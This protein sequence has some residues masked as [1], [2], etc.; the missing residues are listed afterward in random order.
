MI[1]FLLKY[2]FES[3]LF[4]FMPEKWVK[5]MQL[6]RIQKIFEWSKENSEFYK[7]IY[8]DAGIL[9]LQIR[10][11]E[12]IKK[13]PIV[14]KEMILSHETEF[15]LTRPKSANLVITGTSGSTGKPIDIYLTKREHFTSYI[16]TFLALPAYNPFERFVFIGLYKQKE[17]IE[18]QSFLYYCQK[19][20][21]LFRRE[22]FSVFT[23]PE[24]IIERLKGR[25]INILSSTPSC[26]ILLLDELKKS[27]ETL[28]VKYVVVSGE[29]LFDDL[30]DDCKTYLQGKIIDVYGCTEH[31][32]MAWTLPDEDS[33]TYTLN[34]VFVEYINPVEINGDLYGELVITNFV[35]KT[36]PFV[37]Y[38][39]GDHV[40]LLASYKKMGLIKGRADDIME[41]NNGRKVFMYQLYVFFNHI[42][43]FSQYKFLQKKD[44]KIYFQAICKPGVDKQVLEQTVLDAWE[45]HLGDHPF[46]VEF[47][48]EFPLSGETGKFKRME[49]EI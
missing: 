16:R 27:G 26:L 31:P 8:S 37:R 17:K 47:L 28:S 2:Y 34:S 24:E 29:T 36:M 18:R 3:K 32:S 25:K 1:F 6:K 19:Y 46:G 21:G 10:T 42:P 38:K 11:E 22:I 49:V 12:D 40:K 23:S 20:F 5:K 9:D 13:I 7:K 43:G 4:S 39:I 33:Y 30:R 48:T 44:K 45:K 41:L 15:V 14:T 35:N